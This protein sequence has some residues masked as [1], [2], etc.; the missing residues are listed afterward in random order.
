[1]T[2]RKRGSARSASAAGQGDPETD[3]E[4]AATAIAAA[5]RLPSRKTLGWSPHRP[6]SALPPPISPVATSGGAGRREEPTAPRPSL[7]RRRSAKAAGR[8][9]SSASGFRDRERKNRQRRRGVGIRR[10]A[11]T[12]SRRVPGKQARE[13]ELRAC[14]RRRESRKR[15]PKAAEAATVAVAAQTAADRPA[16]DKRNR[17]PSRKAPARRMPRRPTKENRRQLITPS[18]VASRRAVVMLARLATARFRR[19]GK[20]DDDQHAFQAPTEP[21][22]RESP[23]AETISVA[24]L[25]CTRWRVKATE[26][27][28]ALMKMGPW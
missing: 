23:C 18:G 9:V 10:Q 21:V 15:K 17:P 22:V 25:A 11:G 7:R 1:M 24:D 19:Y 4:A 12:A 27:I 8:P 3:G 16:E 5:R 6:C 14:A 26:A 20:R 28:K 2:P 13:A